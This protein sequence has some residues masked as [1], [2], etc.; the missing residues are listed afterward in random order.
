[1]NEI[2]SQTASG[3]YDLSSNKKNDSLKDSNNFIQ[4]NSSKMHVSKV[5]NGQE[6]Y[7]TRAENLSNKDF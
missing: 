7:Q 4:S 5:W 1:M 3:S 6:M 2:I